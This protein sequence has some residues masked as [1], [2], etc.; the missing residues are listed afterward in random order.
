MTSCWGATTS[1]LYSN[2]Y[3]WLCKLDNKC[4][5]KRRHAHPQHTNMEMLWQ[6]RH[7]TH[8]RPCWEPN[9]FTVGYNQFQPCTLDLAHASCSVDSEQV[10]PTPRADSFRRCIWQS[11]PWPGLWVCRTRAGLCQDTPYKGNPKWQR[12]LFV[13]KGEGQ[14]SFLLYTGSGLIL[15][16]SVRRIKQT[17]LL[18]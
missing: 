7:S 15:T 6:K 11:L 18:T 9:A 17:D 2:C 14:H 10:Q 8:S 12:M 4:V 5:C 13:G 16:K 1:L 3:A